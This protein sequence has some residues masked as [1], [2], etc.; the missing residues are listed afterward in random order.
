ME[1]CA[2]AHCCAREIGKLGHEVRLVPPMYVKPFV[3]WQKNDAGDAE[4]IV[5]AD[6]RL[7]RFVVPKTEKQQAC[8]MIF[9]TRDLFV[10]QRMQLINTLRAYLAAHGI[11][12]P[13]GI[14]NL[15]ALTKII[16]GDEIGLDDLCRRNRAALS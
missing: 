10:R 9:R 16:E 2:T 4:A 1:A 12:V 14:A 3:K 11:I 13:L 15:S 8:S 7:S 6:S 5:E